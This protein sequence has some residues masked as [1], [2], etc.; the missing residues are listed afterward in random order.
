MNAYGFWRDNCGIMCARCEGDLYKKIVGDM[1]F[2]QLTE[3][4]ISL[5]MDSM[6]A[7]FHTDEAMAYWL[8][9]Q[10]READNVQLQKLLQ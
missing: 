1:S 4:C 2:K 9:N 10:L 7:H 3:K 6:S 5:G 8:Y